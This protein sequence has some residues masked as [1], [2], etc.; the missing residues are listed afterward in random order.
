MRK[1]VGARYDDFTDGRTDGWTGRHE[2]RYVNGTRVRTA[3]LFGRVWCARSLKPF[4]GA[5]GHTLFLALLLA[6]HGHSVGLAHSL[7]FSLS[8]SHSLHHSLALSLSPST[9]PSVFPFR[10]DWRPSADQWSADRRNGRRR[11]A[12]ALPNVVPPTQHSLAAVASRG[13]RTDP[14]HVASGCLAP[15][16]PK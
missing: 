13:T 3:E 9:P 15:A 2:R 8:L 5:L 16:L 7:N 4:G 14:V 12:A 1:T 11:A 6:V 10:L